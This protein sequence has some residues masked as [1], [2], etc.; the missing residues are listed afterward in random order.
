MNIANLF[1][2]YDAVIAF[3]DAARR[4]KDSSAAAKP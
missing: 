2:A 1:R 4:L 3:R